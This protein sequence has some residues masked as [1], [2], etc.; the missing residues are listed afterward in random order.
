MNMEINQQSPNQPMHHKR[1]LKIKTNENGHTPN[2]S[3][4]MGYSTSSSK[5]E[6]QSNE[7][8]H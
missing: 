8:L 3:E 5:K 6:I 2:I 7:R 4:H 1:N